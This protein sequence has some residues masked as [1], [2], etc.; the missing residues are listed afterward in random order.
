MFVY[1]QFICN[2]ITPPPPPPQLFHQVDG[3]SS[4]SIPI[5][6][7]V[8]L[9]MLLSIAAGV[10]FVKKYVCGGRLVHLS[11]QIHSPVLNPKPF[12]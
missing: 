9:V 4:K 1:L 3:H 8:V 6:V 11:A 10:V 2:C 5:V 12:Y 7:T